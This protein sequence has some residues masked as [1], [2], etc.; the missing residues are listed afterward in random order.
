MREKIIIEVPGKKSGPDHDRKNTIRVL[1]F[2]LGREW[3]CLELNDL[4]GVERIPPVTRV[5]NMPKSIIGVINLRGEIISLID[6]RRFL[7]QRE[8]PELSDRSMAI[9]TDI[10]GGL[11][12]IL[13][14]GIKAAVDIESSSVLP[15]VSAIVGSETEYNRG[16]IRF[17]EE[18]AVLLDLEKILNCRELRELTEFE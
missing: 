16:E 8:R 4:R 3:Y 14:D 5:P 13:A 15:P 2:S 6:I 18:I 1:R 9:L 12:A 11:M 7:G 17:G 10:A